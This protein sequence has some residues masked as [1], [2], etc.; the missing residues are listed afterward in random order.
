MNFIK[1]ALPAL[2]ALA[3]APAHANPIVEIG[4]V[5]APAV[6]TAAALGANLGNLAV[7]SYTASEM[8]ASSIIWGSYFAGGVMTS[9]ASGQV[10]GDST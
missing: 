2:I 8:G 6:K 7:F 10:R 5:T 9:A 3:F 1:L 4:L